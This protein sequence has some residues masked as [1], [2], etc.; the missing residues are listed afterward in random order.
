[1]PYLSWMLIPI[2][3]E[4]WIFDDKY[5]ID[6]KELEFGKVLLLRMANVSEDRIKK[7][8]EIYFEIKADELTLFEAIPLAN[9]LYKQ[10]D[11]IN[12][13]E[14]IALKFNPTPE[15]RRAGI[16]KFNQF[17]ANNTIDA[18]AGG[19]ILKYEQILKIDYNTIFVKLYRSKIE[20]DYEKKYSK[21]MS[22]K[23]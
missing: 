5:K 15:Q 6:I 18:L 3:S 7:A 13:K 14:S 20:H 22:E 9:D 23:K 17:G 11:E 1:M 19:D 16:D 10:L 2:N 21:I 12:K 4:H 8:I